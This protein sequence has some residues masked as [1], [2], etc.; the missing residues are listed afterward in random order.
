[1]ADPVLFIV[2]VGSNIAIRITDQPRIATVD[3]E[4]GGKRRTFQ[5]RNP[6]PL[7][8]V[9][10]FIGDCW[11]FRVI[12]LNRLEGNSLEFGRYRVELWDE[13]SPFATFVAD[14]CDEVSP[15]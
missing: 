14:S 11:E 4:D 10:Q 2:A 8:S 15:D 12:D 13:D 5:F 6:E 1:M 7:A 3:F 9:V